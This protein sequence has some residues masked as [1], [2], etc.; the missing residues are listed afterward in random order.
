MALRFGNGS[1]NNI[2]GTNN[3]DQIFA[4][5]GDDIV[6]ARAG[7]DFV[8]AGGGDDTVFA[9]AGA[10][11]VL[12]GGGADRLFGEAGDDVLV[13]GNGADRLHGG[14]GD[15]ILD[16]GDGADILDGGRG[17]D[18]LT[19]GDGADM[20]D[21]NRLN[22]SG[23]TRAT[24]DH[25]LDFSRAEGDKLDLRGLHLDTTGADADV[26]TVA[27]AG[28][29]TFLRVNTDNDAAFEFQLRLEGNIALSV[30]QD[31]LL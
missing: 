26:V 30:A 10:D 3:A 2:I 13:G 23:A 28:G 17:F 19:G 25:I 31:V 14:I 15:D 5:G 24:A 22:E 11:V 4:F 8:A 1:A 20:F 21:F 16:G 27:H 6:R 12:G 9:G 18:I 7:A 29:D